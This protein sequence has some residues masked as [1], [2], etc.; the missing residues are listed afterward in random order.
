MVE[1]KSQLAIVDDPSAREIYAN[2]LI[3]AT[4]DGGALTITLGVSRIVPN[5][6]NEA[7][8]QGTPPTVHVTVR[9]SLS[10][11]AATNLANALKG[12]LEQISK[13]GA[14]RLKDQKPPSAMPQS[15]TL[16]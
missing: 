9:L 3:G 16:A 7:P 8:T 14:E 4:F 1:K 13:A 11:A 15:K 10:P 6:I 5:K 12:M 2:A